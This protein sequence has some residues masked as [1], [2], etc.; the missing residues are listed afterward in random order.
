M[1]KPVFILL[2]LFTITGAAA[3]GKIDRSKKD[4]N[5]SN[6]GTNN[7]PPSNTTTTSSSSD[8]EPGVLGQLLIDA[9]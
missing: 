2:L 1:K 4:I 3:Q 8:S 7:F 5:N 9:V 6:T